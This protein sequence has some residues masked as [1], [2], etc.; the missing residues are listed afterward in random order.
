[1]GVWPGLRLVGAGGKVAKNF[2][3]VAE[4]GPER[5]VLDGRRTA[6]AD[7]AVPRHH[8]RLLPGAHAEGPRLAPGLRNA[9]LQPAAPLCG[10]Q[11][12]HQLRG[13]A[14]ASLIRFKTSALPAVALVTR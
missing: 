14:T 9:A 13:V 6:A 5:V 1:M 10:G 4:V 7:A 12:G 3:Q 8:L 11:Q 2:V